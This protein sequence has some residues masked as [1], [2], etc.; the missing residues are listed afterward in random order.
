MQSQE[1]IS[2]EVQE[3]EFEHVHETENENAEKET[4][5]WFEIVKDATFG[6]FYAVGGILLVILFLYCTYYWMAM[7]YDRWLST[8]GLIGVGERGYYYDPGNDCFVKPMPN[9]RVLEGCL[10]LE[11]EDGDTI[12]IVKV[13]RGKYR[14]VNLNTLTFINE[15]SYEHA[16]QFRCGIAMAISNDTIYHV[17]A[18][19]R[20]ISSEPSTWI[21]GSVENITYFQEET[22]SDGDSFTEEV[23]TGLLK[24]EDVSG[25]YGLMSSD[26]VRLTP[27]LYSDITAKSKEVFFCEYIDSGMGCLIDKNGNFIK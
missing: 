8:E 2:S 20:I 4:K 21:Y 27:A 24:Y 22:D 5:D 12:G 11:C 6:F 7:G 13:H 14:Y 3:N 9:R 18:N 1:K 15:H 17:S 19:G 25:N 23:S 16:G 26:F 10:T